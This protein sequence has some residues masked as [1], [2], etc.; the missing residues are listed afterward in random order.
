MHTFLLESKGT[1]ATTEISQIQTKMSEVNETRL[2]A[3]RL[4]LTFLLFEFTKF[5]LAPV[6]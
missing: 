1:V 2:R 6:K 5:K 4:L 3:P